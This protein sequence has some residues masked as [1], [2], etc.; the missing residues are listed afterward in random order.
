MKKYKIIKVINNISKEITDQITEEINLTINVNDKK[1]AKL[2]CSN[3]EFE[4]L[5]Y[6][7]LFTAGII[8]KKIDVIKLNIFCVLQEKWQADVKIDTEEINTCSVNIQNTN[9]KDNTAQIKSSDVSRLM[10]SF[11]SKSETFIKTGGVH[12]A[13]IAD[14]K[15]IIVFSEDIGRQNAIDKI[16]GQSLLQNILLSN[17]IIITSCRISSEIILKIA[18]SDIPIII[19]RGAPTDIAINLAEKLNLTLIGFARENRMNIYC[20]NQRIIIS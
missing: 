2:L 19:S 7:Y 4:N 20:G 9:S 8:K 3:M 18:K 15:N 12:S 10:N 14:N 11:G 13:A 5:V 1:V 16:I 6:G 17:K